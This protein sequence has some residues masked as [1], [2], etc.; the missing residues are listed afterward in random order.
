ML[1][2]KLS[3]KDPGSAS[4]QSKIIEG[5]LFKVEGGVTKEELFFLPKQ[6]KGIT[7]K[8]ETDTIDNVVE[9]EE[10]LR[11]NGIN[12]QTINISDSIKTFLKNIKNSEPNR[13]FE[14]ML[15]DFSEIIKVFTKESF[16]D[17]LIMYSPDWN[18]STPISEMS[19]GEKEE[20]FK[21]AIGKF[22]T[23]A[24]PSIPVID[25][26]VNSQITTRNFSVTLEP[27]FDD[28]YTKLIAE[29]RDQIIKSGN[30]ERISRDKIAMMISVNF[31]FDYGLGWYQDIE[32]CKK[33]Y[34][35]LHNEG[36]TLHLADGLTETWRNFP[37]IEVE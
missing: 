17:L 8:H 24:L 23:F 3:I 27:I 12:T 6:Q 21:Q 37:E 29:V 22:K 1:I 34:D 9:I 32:E 31:Y 33:A 30:T 19:D 28:K 2:K 26:K 36:K 10:V 7:V 20:K 5:K 18:F 25:S 15:K 4:I 16:N 13:I 11:L 35:K 14:L